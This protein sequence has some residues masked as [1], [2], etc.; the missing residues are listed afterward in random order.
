[1]ERE[2]I[3]CAK[4]LGV[5][6]KDIYLALAEL[7]YIENVDN[8][9]VYTKRG[10]GIFSFSQVPELLAELQETLDDEADR[11]FLALREAS[12]EANKKIE[13]EWCKKLKHPAEYGRDQDVCTPCYRR[14][15]AMQSRR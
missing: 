3:E 2:V 13:C 14:Y 11:G 4:E 1:M 15:F 7:K 8:K 9:W 12:E 10:E 5:E 6:K